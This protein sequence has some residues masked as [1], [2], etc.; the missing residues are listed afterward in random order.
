MA[1]PEELGGGATNA[2]CRHWAL[3]GFAV[4]TLAFI[5]FPIP[6]VVLMSFSSA[7]SL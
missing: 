2:G 3:A 5:C 1:A 6:I 7:R 4:V